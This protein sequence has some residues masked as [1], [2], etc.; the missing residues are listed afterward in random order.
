METENRTSPDRNAG[1]KA[2]E[3]YRAAC[4]LFDERPDWVTFFR[5]ILG[6]KGIVRESY[7]DAELLRKFEQTRTYLKIQQ[8]LAKLREQGIDPE[9]TPAEPV[10]VITVRIPESL[11]ELLRDEAGDLRTSVNKLCIS[12]LLQL[13][14]KELVPEEATIR[15]NLA[16]AKREREQV[17]QGA[18]AESEED[19]IEKVG[20]DL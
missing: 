17:R 3:V 12:K 18:T 15:A 7:P 11:H 9:V 4:E 19:E 6:R 1:R 8:M 2:A 5:R 16:R 10:R 14:D 13:I 20:E